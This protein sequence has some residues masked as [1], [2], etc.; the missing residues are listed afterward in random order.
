VA[1]LLFLGFIPAGILSLFFGDHFNINF[2]FLLAPYLLFV[3]VYDTY[4]GLTATCP[5]C[6]ELYYW[7][8]EGIGFRNFFTKRCLNCGLDLR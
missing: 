1:I 8:M 7:R 3:V 6:N 2:L 5:M 4:I